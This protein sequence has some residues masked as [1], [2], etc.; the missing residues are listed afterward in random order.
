M[1]VSI[2]K[3]V[4]LFNSKLSSA[5]PT[6]HHSPN[7]TVTQSDLSKLIDDS[8]EDKIIKEADKRTTALLLSQQS[9]HASS[10]KH[11]LSS[12]P[13]PTKLL[14]PDEFQMSL[15]F[16]LGAKVLE[17]GRKCPFCE[18]KDLDPYGDHMLSCM[19]AGHVIHTHNAYRDQLI[20]FARFAGISVQKEITAKL[21]DG[22]TYRADI[23]FPLGIPGFTTKIVLADVTFRNP[24]TDSAIKK[25]S[26][27]SG[28]AAELGEETKEK[29]LSEIL[30]KSN[31]VLIPIGVETLGGIGS[32]CTVLI[33]YILTQLTYR[34]RKP[35]YEIAANFW[36]TLSVLVQRLKS[37]RILRGQQLL[38]TAPRPQ[39]S[40]LNVY[41]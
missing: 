9:P 7:L 28:A 13:G 33:D 35:F 11:Q 18:K 27:W 15:K 40:K 30:E 31:Y 26:K 24:M 10:W 17:E 22:S 39:E 37:N 1:N 19:K 36:Q 29:L 32:E 5:V 38:L 14:R 41:I 16:S 34:L 21:I 4:A 23:V 25:S 12:N 20:E 8:I 3:A 6:I 2:Q